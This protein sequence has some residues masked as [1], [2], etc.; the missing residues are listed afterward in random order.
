MGEAS[1]VYQGVPPPPR[2]VA[3]PRVYIPWAPT[4]SVG[5]WPR[6]DP[7]YLPDPR[8]RPTW[9]PPSP[10]GGDKPH[11]F[12][13]S[14]RS[15]RVEREPMAA[16][17]ACPK[18][19][20]RRPPLAASVKAERSGVPAMG[21]KRPYRPYIP[22]RIAA[23]L[24]VSVLASKTGKLNAL[25]DTVVSR[26]YLT[27]IQVVWTQNDWIPTDDAGPLLIGVSHSD[28]TL[29]E[30][31]EWIEQTQSWDLG[32]KI[33]QERARRSIRRIGIFASGLDKHA[34]VLNDGRPMRTKCGF[35]LLPGQGANLWVYNMGGQSTGDGCTIQGYGTA[36]L[37]PK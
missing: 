3:D 6:R 28:Y 16:A 36:H 31:E 30:V 2:G 5:R 12:F 27:S 19:R 9:S 24:D 29:A 22:G 34:E 26:T 35:M 37:W 17:W 32:D 33:A 21:R 18:A 8:D 1:A 25:G 4:S 23:E 20:R 14:E 15:E 7:E 10:W 11:R 13:T